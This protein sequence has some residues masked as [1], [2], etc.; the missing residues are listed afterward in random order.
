MVVAGF[1]SVT[2]I[3]ARSQREREFLDTV[4]RAAI[5]C[6]KAGEADIDAGSGISFIALT[7]G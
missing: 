1:T 7:L 2:R 6:W 5:V 3:L 4:A